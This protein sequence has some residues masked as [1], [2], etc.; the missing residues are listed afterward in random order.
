MNCNLWTNLSSECNES[1]LFLYS[2][3]STDHAVTKHRF[4]EIFIETRDKA[5]MPAKITARYRASGVY[6]INRSKF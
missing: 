2:H 6:P 4:G 5:A 3:S 1:V